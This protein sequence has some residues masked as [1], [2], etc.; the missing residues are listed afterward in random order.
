MPN[1]LDRAREFVEHVFTELT[2]RAV[3]TMSEAVLIRDGHY[4][5]HRF[6]SGALS[7]VWFFEE[8]QIKVYD[9]AHQVIRVESVDRAEMQPLRRAA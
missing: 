7:A 3:P 6:I 5:G 2:G 4:C 1:Q 9:D 8:D